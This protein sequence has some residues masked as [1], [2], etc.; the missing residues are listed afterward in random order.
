MN[1]VSEADLQS[2]QR[3]VEGFGDPG[4]SLVEGECVIQIA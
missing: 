3:G 2:L 4:V 1:P